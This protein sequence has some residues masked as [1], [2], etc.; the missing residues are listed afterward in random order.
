ML[1]DEWS[2]CVSDFSKYILISLV[3]DFIFSYI[4]DIELVATL[5]YVG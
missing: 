5:D 2:K 3:Q 1:D 4:D